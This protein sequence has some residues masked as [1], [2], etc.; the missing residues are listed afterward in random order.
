MVVEDDADLRAVVVR[1]LERDGHAVTS[2][3][4]GARALEDL[5]GGSRYDLILT[6]LEMPGRTGLEVIRA[7]KGLD[8]AVPV[9]ATSGKG[10]PVQVALDIA[11]RCGADAVIAKPFKL[12]VLVSLVNRVLSGERPEDTESIEELED[13]DVVVIM[14]PDLLGAK[15]RQAEG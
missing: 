8:S 2:R 6:D 12:S 11:R 3:E 15:L 10:R 1:A 14:P 5:E 9:I 13:G 7:A 4:D